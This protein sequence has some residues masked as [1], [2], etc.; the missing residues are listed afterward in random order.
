MSMQDIIR[1][2]ANRMYSY[3]VEM[4]MTQE[5]LADLLGLD[6]SYVSL[7]ERGA[8]VPSLI[9]LDRIAKVFGVRPY[10]LLIE[11]PK[12][13]NYSFKQR[14]LLYMISDG[15]EAQ[16]DKIYRIVKIVNEKPKQN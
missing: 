11:P 12:G 14:E 9:A 13:E 4:K 5:E 1:T 2:F 10:D 6:N 15:T 8:R 7:L 3:R 16:I